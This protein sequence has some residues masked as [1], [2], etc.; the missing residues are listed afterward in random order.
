MAS[1]R[2]ET[3]SSPSKGT[4]EEARLHPLLYELAL[5]ALYQSGIEDNEHGKEE[6]FKSDDLN[7]NSLSAKE[8]VKTFNIYVYPVR[9]QCNGATD[10]MGDFVVNSA[11]GKSFDAF[12]KIMKMVYD[13]LKHRFMYENKDKMDKVW[14]NYCGM[15]V[16]FGWKEFAI[17]SGLKYYPPSP[18]QVIPNLTPK[19]SPRT[20]KKDKGKSSDRNDLVS[21]VGPS[22]KNKNLIEALK[23]QKHDGVINA[24]NALIAFVKKMTSTRSVIPSKKISYPY[25]PLEIKVAK[26]RRKDISKAS[27]SIEKSKI[28]TPLSLSCTTVQCTRSIREQHELMKHIDDIFY[29]L[30]KKAKLQIQEQY[31]YTTGNYLYKVYINNAYDRRHFGPSSEIQKLAKILPT[32]LDMSGF[33]DQK[34]CTDWLTIEAYRDKMDNPFDVQYIEGIAQQIIGSP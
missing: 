25:T 2:K 32:Y 15:P 8:L 23:G 4:S 9:M 6:Y 20:P 1:K 29:Y 18:S 3:E 11:M 12:R 14:I 27:S 22:F 34:I 30:Q 7:A 10:L 24:I 28:S 26:K 16:C 19:K 21:I 13:L 31:I 5:Q 33:L 17:V